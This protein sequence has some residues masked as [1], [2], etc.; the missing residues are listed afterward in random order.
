VSSKDLQKCIEF[1]FA[2]FSDL[3][4]ASICFTFHASHTVPT[5]TH[6]RVM[7]LGLRSIARL[8][9]AR[10]ASL[11]FVRIKCCS[12]LV[13]PI[14]RLRIFS[15]LSVH[16]RSFASQSR[17]RLGHKSLKMANTA[18]AKAS[19]SSLDQLIAQVKQQGETVRQLKADK[20]DKSEITAAVTQLNSLKTK[21]TEAQSKHDATFGSA[22]SDACDE[23]TQLKQLRASLEDL[24]LR[25]FFYVPSFEIYGSVGGLYDF[26]PAGCAVKQNLLAAWRRHFVL[27]E[28]M[29]EVECAAMTPEVV[30]KLVE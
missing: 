10:T 21:L 15:S 6:Q 18:D 24:L 23:K 4:F 20:K 12:P 8:V 29:H 22:S 3:L 25:R 7:P 13:A 1:D 5:F 28:Q 14:I 2:Q 26:G 30:L 9:T 11:H 27:E 16:Q 17:Q 19:Q